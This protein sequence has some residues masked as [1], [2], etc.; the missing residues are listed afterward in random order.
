MSKFT[1]GTWEVGSGRHVIRSIETRRPITFMMGCIDKEQ[2]V[3][4]RL[5]VHAPRMYELLQES[6]LALQRAN[7]DEPL[8]LAIDE[9]L[10][11]IDGDSCPAD[12]EGT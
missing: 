10:C 6:F 8:R 1:Q 7:T 5:I 9:C 12:S 4:T 11:S 2:E 3:N